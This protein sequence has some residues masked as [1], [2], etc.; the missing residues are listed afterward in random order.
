[1]MPSFP[2]GV[3]ILEWKKA[4]EFYRLHRDRL[5]NWLTAD[6]KKFIA[7]KQKPHEAFAMIFAAKEAVSKALGISAAGPEALK[8]IQLK[9][10]TAKKFR[11]LDHKALEVT[12]RRHRRHVVA[13]CHSSQATL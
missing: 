12:V 13:C 11:I 9:P 8:A 3:D 7:S 5:S 10:N 1:M 4:G 2:L 6:E